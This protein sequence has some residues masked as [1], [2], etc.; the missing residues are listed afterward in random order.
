MTG[1]R[2]PQ[3]VGCPNAPASDEG[4][5]R[6][7]EFALAIGVNLQHGQELVVTAPVEAAPLVRHL[8]RCAYRRDASLVTC[9]YEDPDMLRARLRHAADATLDRA[10]TWLYDAVARALERGAA[11]LSVLGPR[12]DL[13][14]DIP[15]ERIV[16][17]H[18][19]L[20][21]AA[22]S[23]QALVSA[24]RINATAVPFAT[25]AWATRVFPDLAPG[26]AK[27]R[28]WEA[29]LTALRADAAD[30]LRAATVHIAALHARSRALQARRL[31]ALRFH[32]GGKTDLTIGLLEGHVW[33]GGTRAAANGVVHVPALPAEE[34]Y[35][36]V[37]S[38]SANGRLFLSRPLLLVGT[39]VE[40][41]HITFSNGAV[42]S[43]RARKGQRA[44]ERLLSLDGGASRLAEVGLVAA[45]SPLG[46]IG[47]FHSPA[48]D[49]HAASR[50]AFGQPDLRCLPGGSPRPPAANRS[51]IHIDCVLGTRTMHV[52]GIDATGRIEPLMRSGEFVIR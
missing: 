26:Q 49:R 22:A 27:R 28:L 3:S 5:E 13:L 34:V 25:D 30:P 10:P 6:L 8:T 19:S 40:D 31:S 11:R 23:E 39:R 45:S 51:S 14:A 41:V 24:G 1:E 2:E 17:I 37:S 47:N 12:P 36:A 29:I 43:V 35:T 16:R 7:A 50:I 4:L 42:T 38:D 20:H 32:D 33:A 18:A 52:D 21:S 46:A 15:L 9:L 48:L 44:L